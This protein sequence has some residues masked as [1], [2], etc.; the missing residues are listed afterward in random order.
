MIRLRTPIPADAEALFP[1]LYQ[2]G[3]CDT[4]QWDGPASFEE[5][6]QGLEQR[7]E[8]AAQGDQHFFIIVLEETGQPVGSADLCPY[9]DGYRASLGLWIGKPYQGRGCG[10]RTIALLLQHGFA[11]PGIEKIEAFVFSGNE[12]SRKAFE[13]NGFTLEGAIRMGTRKRGRYLDEWLLGITRAEYQRRI[14]NQSLI[15]HLC[16][17][18]AWEEH[19]QQPYRSQSLDEGGFIHC[20]KPGQILNVANTFYL[21]EEDLLLL[22][23]DPARLQA[24]LRWEAADGDRFPHIYGTI[25]R[26]AVISVQPF[27]CEKDGVFR[28][29]FQPDF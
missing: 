20:S 27:P 3:V 24:E 19:P 28:S 14:Y 21:G 13:N 8:L 29:F 10:T 7:A 5:Y 17:R 11:L 4:L 6:R 15:V 18:A 23:I 26:E 22:W 16:K 1:L 12:A 9:E 2:T 25:N